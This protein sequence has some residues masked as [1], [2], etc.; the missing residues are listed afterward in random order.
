MLLNKTCCY[1]FSLCGGNENAPVTVLSVCFS[2]P[3]F[4]FL[5]VGLT[6]QCSYD[7]VHH[8]L[9]PLLSS[10][11]SPGDSNLSFALCSRCGRPEGCRILVYRGIHQELVNAA[12]MWAL[13]ETRLL[14]RGLGL[15]TNLHYKTN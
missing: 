2:F 9:F 11:P 1:K 10:L 6:E 7:C 15:D 4:F 3:L 12:R 14:N 13:M 8:S 5:C